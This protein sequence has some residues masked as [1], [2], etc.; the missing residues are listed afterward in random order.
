MHRTLVELEPV[1]HASGDDYQIVAPAGCLDRGRQTV[2][3]GALAQ[4]PEA[5]RRL[6]L[7]EHPEIR[8]DHM[9]VDAADHSAG[10]SHQVPL[11]RRR[12]ESPG[13]PEDLREGPAGVLVHLQRAPED[14]LRKRLHGA[15]STR[16]RGAR[17]REREH[18]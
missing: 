10:R 2:G 3:R 15:D 12:A 6:P 9:H 7:E 14:A 13:D 1:G 16:D 17:M 8:M 18:S 4:I 5:N 11:D